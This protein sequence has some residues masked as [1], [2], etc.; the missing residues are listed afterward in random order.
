MPVGSGDLVRQPLPLCCMMKVDDE[1]L[2]KASLA[3]PPNI[4]H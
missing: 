4:A 1:S 3:C 2:K